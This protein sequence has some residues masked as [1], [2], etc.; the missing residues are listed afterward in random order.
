[1]S[2]VKFGEQVATLAS[3][4]TGGFIPDPS[5][6][7]RDV[8]DPTRDL[9]K[10]G[11][12][13]SYQS[14]SYALMPGLGGQLNQML[15]ENGWAEAEDIWPCTTNFTT[16]AAQASVA[17]VNDAMRWTWGRELSGK[18][19]PVTTAMNLAVISATA[20]NSHLFGGLV[21][22]L[23]GGKG[24]DIKRVELVCKNEGI[25]FNSV[26]FEVVEPNEAMA[27]RV[28]RQYVATGRATVVVKHSTIEAWVE[29]VL[30]DY[31]RAGTARLIINNLGFH[32]AMANAENGDRFMC[33]LNHVLSDDGK[34]LGSM[35]DFESADTFVRSQFNDA[36]VGTEMLGV[37]PA[38]EMCTD[39]KFHMRVQ[40]YEFM[41]PQVER[42][43]IYSTAAKHDLSVWLIPS[44]LLTS[45]KRSA[46]LH[47]NPPINLVQTA[48]RK[49]LEMVLY[50]EIARKSHH[51]DFVPTPSGEALP[52]WVFV[53]GDH[54]VKGPEFPINHGVVFGPLD[55]LHYQPH[56]IAV[57]EKHNG[58]SS[59]VVVQKHVAHLWGEDGTYWVSKVVDIPDSIALE[60]QVEYFPAGEGRM[61]KKPVIVDVL[62][63]PSHQVS[64]RARWMEAEALFGALPVLKSLFSLNHWEFNPTA[65]DLDLLW[66][67]VEEGIVVQDLWA[68]PPSAGLDGS[69]RYIKKVV[70]KDVLVEADGQVYEVPIDWPVADDPRRCPTV[71]RRLD[72]SIANSLVQVKKM[73]MALKYDE[74][75]AICHGLL[76]R[77]SH[78]QGAIYHGIRNTMVKQWAGEEL[79]TQELAMFY[80]NQRYAGQFR[81]VF[82]R[83]FGT[84]EREFDATV[85]DLHNM[86]LQRVE[87]SSQPLLTLVGHISAMQRDQR[88]TVSYGDAGCEDSC[89]F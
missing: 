57:G 44:R 62:K 63:L 21:V 87:K 31:T 14:M 39:G 71:R 70:T 52:E 37:Y 49:E 12:S 16:S 54:N 73:Q 82:L 64:F 40:G 25:D 29:D 41:D 35:I 2:N 55:V 86:F 43:R 69:A 3:V 13:S 59:R 83:R 65:S 32:H 42:S 17:I 23:G 8:P 4:R 28:S 22:V 76:T 89:E 11:V 60:L 36:L 56:R 50:V 66:E 24:A 77:G 51:V 58:V 18:T 88:V 10:M 15:E 79:E 84:L 1:M 53:S 33:A 47:Y 27:A 81:Q 75:R 7:G 80:L 6:V 45:A 26:R 68:P 5:D 19:N 67:G 46:G 48:M 34:Y 78:R 9:I 30:G 74:F 72:K 61:K 85:A 38:D 20:G